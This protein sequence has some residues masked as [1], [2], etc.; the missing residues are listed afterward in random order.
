MTKYHGKSIFFFL[1]SVLLASSPTDNEVYPRDSDVSGRFFCSSKTD[2]VNVPSLVFSSVGLTA[3]IDV[4]RFVVLFS[5]VWTRD[6]RLFLGRDFLNSVI[7]KKVTGKTMML[8][9][10]P[11][12]IYKKQNISYSYYYTKYSLI[13][14]ETFIF[15]L[16]LKPIYWVILHTAKKQ[17]AYLKL[18]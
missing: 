2:G 1:P 7:I 10:T 4:A 5:A 15:R 3:V 18:A 11:M 13:W 17:Y 6:G 14:R 16:S 8:L 9:I 12:Y